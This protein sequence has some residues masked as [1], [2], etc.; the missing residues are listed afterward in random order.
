MEVNRALVRHPINSDI[1][2]QD[3]EPDQDDFPGFGL[4]TDARRN[5]LGLML[6]GFVAAF[7]FVATL[8]SIQPFYYIL[9][10]KAA[11]YGFVVG[12][13]DLAQFC[14]APLFAYLST[15]L[16]FKWTSILGMSL[17]VL[18]N[19]LYSLLLVIEDGGAQNGHL[20]LGWK[21]MIL[22]RLIMGTGSAIL[23]VGTSYFATHTSLKGR[24]LALGGYRM[25]QTVARMAGPLVG[26]CFISMDDPC[27]P[28]ADEHCS[29]ANI[30]TQL[31]NF[32][33]MPSWLAVG[34]GL[35]VILAFVTLFKDDAVPTVH[36]QGH[37]YDFSTDASPVK[38]VTSVM[39]FALFIWGVGYWSL[40]SQVF[41]FSLARFKIVE[42]QGEIWKPYTAIGA[43]SLFASK[44]WTHLAKNG[45][46][47][48]RF[49]PISLLF[50]LCAP[51][52]MYKYSDATPQS[53]Q[54][55]SACVLMGLCVTL[56]FANFEVIYTKVLT[57]QAEAV[58]SSVAYFMALYN[59]AGAAGRFAGPVIG[60]LVMTLNNNCQ[61]VFDDFKQKYASDW[62]DEMNDASACPAD[63][64]KDTCCVL[65][66]FFCAGACEIANANLFLVIVAGSALLTLG[67]VKFV[68]SRAQYPSDADTALLL[69]ESKAQ[70]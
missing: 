60:G 50:G 36:I 54:L 1:E 51:M 11:L 27:A 21:A 67:L 69:N 6:I 43:G 59:M 58:G 62:I 34:V 41:N 35:A 17:T 3:Q 68:L 18:G 42:Q 20:G 32:Y 38:P 40:M 64:K 55:Y 23:I 31:F 52:L 44:V 37:P 66:S 39:L 46:S 30:T 61:P 9:N 63:L 70:E 53:F 7:D 65:T 2:P 33:T 57:W 47:E 26:F 8:M 4:D 5:F 24:K 25:S 12:S 56:F 13:Y 45:M 16:G 29:D 15:V 49:V 10:G 19:V 14:A 22:A 28:N 48:K